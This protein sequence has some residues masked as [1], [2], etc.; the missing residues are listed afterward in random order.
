LDFPKGKAPLIFTPG[1]P[2]I[3]SISFNPFYIMQG[4]SP[5]MHIDY[6]KDIFT[7]SF[8]FYGPMP[9]I[10]EKCLHNVYLKRG[11]NLSMGYHPYL[12]NTKSETHL[13]DSEYVGKQYSHIEHKYVFPTMQDLKNEIES[14][15]KEMGYE[16]ELP[17]NIKTAILARLES[18]CVGAKGFMFNTSNAPDF[19]SLLNKNVVFELEGLADDSDKAFIV[20]I[21]IIYLTEYRMYEKEISSDYQSSL[22]HLLVIEEAHRLLKNISTEKISEDSGNPKGK[23][24]EH[25]TNMVAEMRSYGQGVIIS[26]QIPSKIAS[27]VIKNSSNKIIHRIVAR[28]DQEI[29]ANMIGMENKDTVFLDDQLKGRALCHSEG[30]R[31]PISVAFP[32]VTEIDRKDGELRRQAM[33]QNNQNF[34]I[35]K[36]LLLPC[37]SEIDTEIP[38]LLNT[39][40]SF[41]ESN[42]I[43]SIKNIKKDAESK[44]KLD[45]PRLLRE[46]QYDKAIA[47]IL[48]EL[49][50][51]Y[52]FAGIYY[53]EKL[54]E[55]LFAKIEDAIL[56]PYDEPIAALRNAFIEIDNK[57]DMVVHIVSELALSYGYSHQDKEIDLNKLVKSYFIKVDEETVFKIIFRIQERMEY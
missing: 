35:L 41:N 44:V 54:P 50:I 22:K 14:Y 24:V 27:D 9:Y 30:M 20:G 33:E 26:E 39:F 34:Y 7:A 8:S 17:A 23:A 12:A 49:S 18:L 19:T 15:V 4:I 47:A 43:A 46:N 42:I 29:I 13:F 53:V 51:K 10:L 38:K 6:L 5:Q 31:L 1:K 25:F 40:L 11:W 2:E 16:G 45:S 57:S 48:A 21:V 3:N 55:N 56:N 37:L 32:K 28:D 36:S 52:L